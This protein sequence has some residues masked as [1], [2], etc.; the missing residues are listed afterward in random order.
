MSQYDPLSRDSSYYSAS[1]GASY[2]WL[3]ALVGVAILLVASIL[4]TLAPTAKTHLAR[5]QL[6]TPTHGSV[7][8][9][10]I[11]AAPLLSVLPVQFQ[12]VHHA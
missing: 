4:L 9:R 5:Q 3:F 7:R 12:G 11:L 8:P 1:D 10:V 6:K 2:G